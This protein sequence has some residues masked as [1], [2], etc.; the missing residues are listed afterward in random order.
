M[1]HF[2]DV[3]PSLPRLL[4]KMLLGCRSLASIVSMIEEP[5]KISGEY[6]L[7]RTF[8]SEIFKSITLY[9]PQGT[10]DKYKATEGWKDFAL[11]KELI[12]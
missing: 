4:E 7:D 10:M 9:V 11:I 2:V 1:K 12:P 6:W 5:F 8:D 3:Q